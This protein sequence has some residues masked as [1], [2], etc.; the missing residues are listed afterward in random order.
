MKPEELHAYTQDLIAQ[1]EAIEQNL[2]ELVIYSNGGISY[3]AICQMP[4]SQ[5]RTLE[6]IIS[7]KIKQDK[8]IK[9]QSM[10]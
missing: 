5:I 6:K 7:K 9:E 1:A 3:D 8:G 10:L 4:V 2:L